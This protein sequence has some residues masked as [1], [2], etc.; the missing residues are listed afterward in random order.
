MRKMRLINVMYC[1]TYKQKE[2]NNLICAYVEVN[3]VG[4]NALLR[5][6]C[7]VCGRYQKVLVLCIHPC[8][9]VVFRVCLIIN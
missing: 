7:T 2:T 8:D 6:Y 5:Q 1:H 3:L 9:T 4:L